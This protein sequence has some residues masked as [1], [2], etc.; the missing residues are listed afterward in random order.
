VTDGGGGTAVESS[1]NRTVILLGV[2]A[3]ALIAIVVWQVLRGSGTSG[4]APAVDDD[5]GSGAGETGDVAADDGE[6]LPPDRGPTEPASPDVDPV[7]AIASLKR[8]LRE[9]RLWASVSTN[10]ST[11]V[12]ESS[13]CEDPGFGAIV[14]S[15]TD[16]LRAAAFTAIRCR[17]QHG[18]TV[19]EHSL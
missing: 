1:G 19:F 12:V 3:A 11:V 15:A 9:Q 5:P 8:A 14:A 16:E 13:F 17:A 7:N 6:E 4:A 2:A 10:G 18:E